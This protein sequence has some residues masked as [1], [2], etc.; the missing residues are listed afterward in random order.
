MIVYTPKVKFHP[1]H[2][3]HKKTKIKRTIQL[4]KP[5]A[6]VKTGCILP[7]QALTPSAFMFFQFHSRQYIDQAKYIEEQWN[8]IRT[9]KFKPCFLVDTVYLQSQLKQNVSFIRAN[10]KLIMSFLKV[11]AL[12]R[13]YKYGKKMKNLEDPITLNFTIEPVCIYDNRAKGVFTFDAKS[14]K[15]SIETNLFAND[16][17]FVEPQEPKNVLTNLPFTK[18]QF[19]SIY[20]QL[21]KYGHTSWAIEAYKK[22]NMDL[23]LFSKVYSVGLQIEALKSLIRNPT[24]IEFQTLLTEFVEDYYVQSSNTLLI[25][26][27]TIYWAIEHEP[28]C[29]YILRWIRLF[30]RYYTLK[31]TMGNLNTA[32]GRLQKAEIF[33][34]AKKL[35]QDTQQIH[36]L[37]LKKRR[38]LM[39]ERTAMSI[40]TSASNPSLSSSSDQGDLALSLPPL[41]PI[42]TIIPLAHINSEDVD[43]FILGEL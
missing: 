41:V 20:Y 13:Q 9:L 16:W 37:T 8:H 35:L 32:Q 22:M 4:K 30:E 43:I 36:L 7:L 33:L 29:D 21:R 25:N 15:K 24:S 26:I 5:L 3:P 40:S 6:L 19:I 18:A 2:F 27:D 11:L 34:Q 17:L 10:R 23:S 39:R 31:I 1:G 12:W 14:L 38:I 42:G 28:Q